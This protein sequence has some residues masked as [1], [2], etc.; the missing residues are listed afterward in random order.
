MWQQEEKQLWET[1]I[2]D[3][4][5]VLRSELMGEL[6]GPCIRSIGPFSSLSDRMVSQL[7]GVCA[8]VQGELACECQ[9]QHGT[10]HQGL[11]EARRVGCAFN[12]FEHL[13]CHTCER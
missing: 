3:L 1:C 8:F 2:G 4:G 13:R 6:V 10:L 7:A 12:V 9:K 5:P 11:K